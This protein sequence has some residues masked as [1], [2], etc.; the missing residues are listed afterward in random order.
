V[1]DLFYVYVLKCRDESLYTGYT[2]DIEKRLIKHNNGKASKYT[3]SRLPVELIYFEEYSTKSQAM[4]R[5]AAIKNLS[6]DE[7]LVLINE[8]I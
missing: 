3:R 1:I 8:V 2:D 7:K 4:T 5:E 6:R